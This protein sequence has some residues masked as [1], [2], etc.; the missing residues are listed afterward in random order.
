MKPARAFPDAPSGSAP[1][2]A[3]P[4]ALATALEALSQTKLLLD[5]ASLPDLTLEE[6]SLAH[7]APAATRDASLDSPSTMSAQRRPLQ[8]VAQIIHTALGAKAVGFL[9]ADPAQQGLV[10]AGSAGVSES[11]VASGA[12][13]VLDRVFAS[14]AT[15]CEDALTT[16]AATQRLLEWLGAT[17]LLAVPISVEGKPRGVLYVAG[18]RPRACDGGDLACLMLV[19]SRVGLLL[20]RAELTRAQ[21]ETER[22]RAQ[23]AARQ[24]FLGIVT[25][26][27]KTPVAVLRAYTELLLGRAEQAGRSDEVQLLQRMDDQTERL[28]AM[29]EQLLDVQRLDAGLFPLEISRVDL[30]ALVT[31]VIEGLQLTAGQVSL[32]VQAEAG[33]EVRADRRRIE[34]VLIN[35]IQNAIR[36]SPPGEEVVVRVRPA[37]GL[38]GRSSSGAPMVPGDALPTPSATGLPER[39]ILVSVSDRGPGVSEKDRAHIF[40]RFYQGQMGDR[41]HRGRGG[42]GVGLYIAREIVARHGGDLWLQPEVPGA[43]GATFAFVLRAAGPDQG[44]EHR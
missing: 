28:L 16:D 14:G 3:P 5:L 9:L 30:A 8:H 12:E 11:A 23:A 18:D 17:T 19:A 37:E 39:W 44:E 6:S 1:A 33:V 20:E 31:C 4:V 27:L 32:R 29:I 21:R 7:P 41:L 26:E 38:A 24:E 36:F 22:Q 25:H 10:P 43:A 34:Q 42:F 40:A 15:L 35:L 2:S 13:A